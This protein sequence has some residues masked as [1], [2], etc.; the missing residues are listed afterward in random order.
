MN[1]FE[2]AKEL[3]QK[4]KRFKIKKAPKQLYP[5]AIERQ[6]QLSL[7]KIVRQQHDL[8]KQYLYPELPKFAREYNIDTYADDTQDIT[9]FVDQ[10]MNGELNSM[11]TRN[12]VYSTA[13]SISTFNKKQIDKVFRKMI[14]ID[15]FAGD[16]DLQKAISPFVTENVSLIKTIPQEYSKRVRNVISVGARNGFTSTEVA[17][18]L[19]KEFKITKNRARLIARDQVGKFN[20]QLTRLRQSRVGVTEYIWRTSLDERVRGNPS[21]LY[22]SA[23]PSHWIREGKKFKYKKPPSDGNPGEP[24]QCRCTAEPV[25]DL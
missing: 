6:Y 11:L 21:G 14:G 13:L 10:I 24:I 1:L 18:L 9:N 3:K 2:V 16:I 5:M 19:E 12:M 8:L 4:S 22:P 17:N 23:S 15:I 25:I 7:L 20:G